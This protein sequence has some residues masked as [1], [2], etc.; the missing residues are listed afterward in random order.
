MAIAANVLDAPTKMADYLEL[1][2]NANG[3]S[4]I[5]EASQGYL[6]SWSHE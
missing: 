6:A 5:I 2:A 3:I 4:A 1:M